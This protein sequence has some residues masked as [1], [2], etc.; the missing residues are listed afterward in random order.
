[1]AVARGNTKHGLAIWS[2][3]LARPAESSSY[4]AWW[5]CFM[6]VLFEAAKACGAVD[7]MKGVVAIAEETASRNPEVATL[8][9]IAVNLRG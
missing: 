5:P 1:L 4:S 6:P 2:Q 9:G 7:L 3:L 8:N